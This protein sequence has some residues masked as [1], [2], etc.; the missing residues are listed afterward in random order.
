VGTL[1]V[2]GVPA[3]DPEDLTL[4]ARRL[5]SE[6][7]HVVTEEVERVRALLTHHGITARL[8]GLGT[9]GAVLALLEDGDLALAVDGWPGEAG[10]RLVWAAAERGYEVIAVP[11]PALPITAVILSGL[12]ADAFFYLGDLPGEATAR[13]RWVSAVTGERHTLVALASPPLGDVLFDLHQQLGDRPLAIVP[14]SSQESGAIWRGSL[15]KAVGEAVSWPQAERYA[16]V[17]GGAPQQQ[18]WDEERLAAEIE[19]RLAQGQRAKEIS[20]QLAEESG[21]SRRDIY[22]RVLELTR[23]GK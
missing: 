6:A 5:L 4:R 8:S 23:G 16:L 13:R 7:G 1:S 19:V 20:R 2:I 18:D 9:D 17:V 11:G 14:A 15:I 21:W 10:C 3:G 12:P 22:G